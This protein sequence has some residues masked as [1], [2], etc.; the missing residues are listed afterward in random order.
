[1]G[2]CALAFRREIGLHSG[3]KQTAVVM[4][5]YIDGDDFERFG[6]KSCRGTA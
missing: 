5:R 3:K 2:L 1:M 6:D 4:G